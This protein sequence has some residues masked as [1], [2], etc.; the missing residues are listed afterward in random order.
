MNETFLP[1]SRQEI[2]ED[3]IAEVIRVLRG[4]WL[5]TGPEVRRF[6]EALASYCTARYAVV[7]ANGTVA[8]HLAMMALDVQ[9]GDG[10]ITS[11]IT[12]L[13][14]ANSARFVG[15]EVNFADVEPLTI[16]L[17]PHKVEPILAK[18]AGRIKVLLPVHFGGHPAR[19]AE[20]AS[21]ADQY[22]VRIIED[23]CH[24]LGAAYRDNSGE[25]VKVG[26]CRHSD[27]SIFSF[28][29]VKG[30]TTGEGGAITT[31][32]RSLYERLLLFRSHGMI[33]HEGADFS[34]QNA[35]LAYDAAGAVVPWYYEM[36]ALGYNYRITDFQCALGRS[37]LSKVERFLAAKTQLVACYWRRLADSTLL[38]RLVKPLGTDKSVRHGHHLFVVQIR[39]AEAGVDRPELV[40]RLH[41]RGI[42]TQV[43]YIPLHLQ[44]YYRQHTGLRPGDLPIAEAYYQSCLSLPLFPAMTERDVDRVVAALEISLTRGSQ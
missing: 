18:Q 34:F 42:G 15:A 37:Q 44:P 29:P 26:S 27:L 14:T 35:N 31:N 38:S 41:A 3:D 8:L 36:H 9:P 6:E 5:T 28:H 19:M 2:S 12:F 23:A 16:T 4:E 20:F 22:G 25:M 10:V 39:F 43:H 32:D 7:C 24:A 17:D 1:Y 30:I 33:R 21:V 11:P 40:K 13:A